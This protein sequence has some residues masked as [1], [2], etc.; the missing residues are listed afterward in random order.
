MKANEVIKQYS[1]R[2]FLAKETKMQSEYLDDWHCHPWHQVIFPISGLLQSSVSDKNY[3]VPHNGFLFIP[4]N[5]QHKSI[6]ITN[7]QFLAIYLNPNKL[8]NCSKNLF[9]VWLVLS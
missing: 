9:L 8:I 6:A 3:I 2:L 4:A 1:K 7:T 5:F